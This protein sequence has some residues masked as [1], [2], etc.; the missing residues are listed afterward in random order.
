MKPGIA[1]L[2]T[3]ALASAADGPSRQ[4]ITGVAHMAIYVHDIAR[5]RAFYHDLLGYDEP[6]HLDNPDG[7]LSMTFFKIND[8]QYIEVFPEKAPGTDRM[9]HIALETDDAE[10]MLRYLAAKGVKVPDKVGVGRIRNKNFNIADPDGHTVEMVQYMPDS[11]TVREKGKYLPERVSSR[12][13][14][15]GILVGTLQS[16][17]DF[18]GGILGFHEF[19]RGSSNGKVL[20]WTNMRVPDGDTYIEFMLYDQLPAPTARG[21]AHHM[22]LEVPD[23]DKAKAWLQ[24]RPAFKQYTRPLEIHTG[25]NR[26]RQLNLYDPDGTR[27]EL[28]E[29]NPVDGKPS[30]SSTAAPPR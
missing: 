6:Y 22:C 25:V 23:V 26:K 13:M 9:S 21:T 14:H 16:A 28:M 3:V 18:Y 7:S 17:I 27:L 5:S 2:A 12:M 20:S 10:A 29:P 11:W 19:W 30:P 1:L 8:R 4:R 24:A 15:V